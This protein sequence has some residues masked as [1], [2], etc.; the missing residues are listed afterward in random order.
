VEDDLLKKT[1][2]AANSRGLSRSQMISA[3]LRLLLID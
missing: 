3:G 1:D 2:Q